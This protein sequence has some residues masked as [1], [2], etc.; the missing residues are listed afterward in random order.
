L[1]PE[2]VSAASG[3]APTLGEL[4]RESLSCQFWMRL[5]ND[6]VGGDQR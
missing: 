4:G 5:A 6:A 2:V 3:S 1:K